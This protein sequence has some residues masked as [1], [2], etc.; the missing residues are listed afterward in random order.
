MYVYNYFI[1]ADLGERAGREQAAV[2]VR[3]VDLVG[4]QPGAGQSTHLATGSS[5][6]RIDYTLLNNELILKILN[7]TPFKRKIRKHFISFLILYFNKYR[8]KKVYFF[9]CVRRKREQIRF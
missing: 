7:S 8:N 3:A 4:H 9:V 1:F 2:L 5:F 6:F